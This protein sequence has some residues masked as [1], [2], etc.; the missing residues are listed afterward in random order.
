MELNEQLL[1]YLRKNDRE[2]VEDTLALVKQEMVEQQYSADYANAAIMGILSVCLS[3]IVEM[4]GDIG[5]ILGEH[6]SP[7]QS[8]GNMHSLE[9]SFQ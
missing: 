5:E 7:Y 8:L 2:K 9:E 6:F 4:K 3:Y 1:G